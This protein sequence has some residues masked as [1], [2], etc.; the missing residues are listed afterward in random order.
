L[1]RYSRKKPNND[2]G[3]EPDGGGDDIGRRIPDIAKD[4]IDSVTGAVD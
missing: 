2:P 3:N 1:D 4:I